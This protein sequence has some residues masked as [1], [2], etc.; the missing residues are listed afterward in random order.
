[1]LYMCRKNHITYSTY[2][3]KRQEGESA[4]MRACVHVCVCMCMCVRVCVCVCACTR[5]HMNRYE[6]EG[7]FSN[8]VYFYFLF[9]DLVM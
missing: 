9:C 5:A 3:C 8:V 2:P 7:I 1:M 4:S 6:L